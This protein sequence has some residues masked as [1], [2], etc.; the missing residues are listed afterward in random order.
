MLEEVNDDAIAKI[1]RAVATRLEP[2]V[3]AKFS[4]LEARLSNMELALAPVGGRTIHDINTHLTVGADGIERLA[5]SYEKL[6][7]LLNTAFT[8]EQERLMLRRRFDDFEERVRGRLA[9]F[10]ERLDAI[11]LKA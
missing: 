3:D 8:N 9:E 1:A 6:C 7:E 2:I 11:A 10:K 4:R 5:G